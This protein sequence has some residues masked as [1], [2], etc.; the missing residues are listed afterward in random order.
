VLNLIQQ[1]LS[2]PFT[3]V[4][5]AATGRCDPAIHGGVPFAATQAAD[6]NPQVSVCDSFFTSSRDLQRDVI[7]HKYFHLLDLGDHS[8]D[9]MADA[10]TNA[11][12]IAQVVVLVHDRF[13]QQNS[14]G[15]EPAIPPGVPGAHATRVTRQQA[16]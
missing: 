5:Q 15:N 4:D 9:T 6:P 11:N 8:A 10:L 14:D 12:T 2:Q 7:T 3:F 1:N 16:M 13:R